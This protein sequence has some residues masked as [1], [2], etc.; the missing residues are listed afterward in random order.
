MPKRPPQ[1]L[2]ALTAWQVLVHEAGIQKGQHLLMHAAAGGVGH[3][4]VQIAK[5][6]GATVTGTASAANAAYLKELGVDAVIDYT[7]EDFEA[8]IKD[9]DIVFDPLGGE[10]TQRS[11]NVLKPG[12]TLISIV[13]G[14]KEN[15]ASVVSEKNIKAKNYLVHSSGEDMAQIARMLEQGKLRSTV[16]HQFAFTEMAKAHQQI[17]TGKTKGKVVVSTFTAEQ[18]M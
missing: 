2:A 6:F 5:H 7:S 4:A 8:K 15:L 12:G 3:Y 1:R 16:S 14:V 17:E 11:L 18:K 10:I 13:G 9:V